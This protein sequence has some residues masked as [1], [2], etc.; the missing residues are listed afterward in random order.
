MAEVWLR[1]ECHPRS[2]KTARVGR[3]TLAERKSKGE[4][5][6]FARYWARNFPVRGLNDDA[7]AEN[8]CSRSGRLTWLAAS[9]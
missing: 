7:E 8:L 2:S 6:I 9:E 3:R 4:S 5:L 1:E